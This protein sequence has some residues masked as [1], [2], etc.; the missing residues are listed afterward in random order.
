MY[1]EELN[2]S[3]Y[4]GT[5]QGIDE[6][7]TTEQIIEQ[8]HPCADP[9]C[10]LNNPYVNNEDILNEVEEDDYGSSS[11]EI[12]D[13]NVDQLYEGL[14]PQMQQVSQLSET[15]IPNLAKQPELPIFD[16]DYETYLNKLND[17]RAAQP[18]DFEGTTSFSSLHTSHKTKV[19]PLIPILSFM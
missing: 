7:L 17:P 16:G 18:E 4:K 6:G 10:D 12:N 14:S 5:N 8:N 19:F 15:R 11:H 2:R 3:Y 9:D 13:S 1:H